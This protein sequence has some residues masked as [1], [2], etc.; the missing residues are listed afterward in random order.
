[1]AK[2]SSKP[3]MNTDKRRSAEPLCALLSV[4]LR[5]CGESSR[6]IVRLNAT[7]HLHHRFALVLRFFTTRPLK[8]T[9]A[10][11]EVE[12]PEPRAARDDVMNEAEI[13]N[14]EQQL[15]REEVRS[16]A[17]RVAE[18]LADG[19]IEYGSSGRIYLYARGDTLG[20]GSQREPCAGD[21][22]VGRPQ[23]R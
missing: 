1:M 20:H 7:R 10:V 12:T 6:C 18:L 13:L 21:R 2:S 3:L 5:L 19:F 11:Q 15:L 8:P 23:R 4:S 9:I 22:A 16:S 17:D 14:L